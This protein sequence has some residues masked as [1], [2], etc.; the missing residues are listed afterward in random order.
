M[1][2][3]PK[4]LAL[5]NDLLAYC[6]GALSEAHTSEGFAT[7]ASQSKRPAPSQISNYDE[8]LCGQAAHQSKMIT[9]ALS[10]QMA[11]EGSRGK[12]R[13]KEEQIHSHQLWKERQYR[14]V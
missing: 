1:Q 4:R 6:S 12:M 13:H 8:L 5:G 11:G 14:R 10:F 9:E 7:T 3:S 2:L